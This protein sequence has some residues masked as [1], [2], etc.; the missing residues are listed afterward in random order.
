M[1]RAV[2]PRYRAGDG[3]HA[4]RFDGELVIVDLAR[5]NYFGLDEVGAEIW[6]GLLRGE[7]IAIVVSRLEQSFDASRTELEA[8]ASG[9]VRELLAN[10]LLVAEETEGEPLDEPR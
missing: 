1:I 3:V 8:D 7:S 5:G 2:E 9:L 10:G 4:R 6:E